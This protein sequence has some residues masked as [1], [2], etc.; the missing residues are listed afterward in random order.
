MKDEES[1]IFVPL[2]VNG[3][4]RMELLAHTVPKRIDYYT[5]LKVVA[6]VWL[7]RKAITEPV[8]E[9]FEGHSDLVVSTYKPVA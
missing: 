6:R 8:V 5:N 7:L 1:R 2:L 4:I 9:T 3:M